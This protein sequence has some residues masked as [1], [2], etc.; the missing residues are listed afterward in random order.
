MT[1]NKQLIPLLIT[2]ITCSAL[3]VVL[4]F[5]IQLLNLFPITG[6]I[7][8]QLRI[9]DMLVGLTIYL[10]TS[11]D[12][13]LFIASLMTKFTG[14]KNRI[15][16]EIGTALGNAGGTLFV[17]LI[18]T[19]FKEVPLLMIVMIL[20]ASL[21]LLSLAQEG[22][23]EFEISIRSTSSGQDITFKILKRIV[24]TSQKILHTVN[25]LFHPLLKSIIPHPP[26]QI[27]DKKTF[28][29]LFLFAC[30][31]PLLLGLDD[32][33]GYIPLFNIINVFGFAVGVFVGHMLLNL[34]LFASPTTTIRIVK[35]PVIALF[36]SIAFIGIALWG[37]VEAL[38]ILF[39]I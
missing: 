16:I 15:A 33:A 35:Q 6:K 8:P 25:A 20:L 9:A 24:L 31:I 11:I 27:A 37:F 21:V 19:F 2:G 34:F 13:A 3:I 23:N 36:G 22:L 28:F 39:T 12:F 10:K 30:T 14:I 7:I 18:W 26:K 29:A 17:L 32:F 38:K 1:M 5:F 4:F